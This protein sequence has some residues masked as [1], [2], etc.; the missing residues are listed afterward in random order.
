MEGIQGFGEKTLMEDY[1]LDD[2]GADVKILKQ[3]WGGWIELD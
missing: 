1:H 2:L 3:N